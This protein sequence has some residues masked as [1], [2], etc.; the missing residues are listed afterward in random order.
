MK[1]RSMNCL[2]LNDRLEQFKLYPTS[3]NPNLQPPHVFIWSKPIMFWE[4]MSL[5]PSPQSIVKNP[6]KSSY[7][8]L[9]LIWIHSFQGF[10]YLWLPQVSEAKPI[11]CIYQ[12]HKMIIRSATKID[13]THDHSLHGGCLAKH[14]TFFRH[15]PPTS[16]RY[17]WAAAFP[18][19]ERDAR[20]EQCAENRRGKKPTTK[21]WKWP[22]TIYTYLEPKWLRVT[23]E[24]SKSWLPMKHAWKSPCSSMNKIGS[25]NRVPGFVCDLFELRPYALRESDMLMDNSSSVHR[26]I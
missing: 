15:V 16:C 25:C 12:K 23:L 1:K 13:M 26:E 8:N 7:R 2:T 22:H 6:E 17:A 20:R 24:N 3:L 9:K 14:G 10:D 18:G 5:Q 11:C 4:Q 19:S 21:W